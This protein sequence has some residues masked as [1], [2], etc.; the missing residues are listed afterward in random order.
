MI[1]LGALASSCVSSPPPEA[2]PELKPA[3]IE[4][5]RLPSP[6][7]TEAGVALVAPE[8]PPAAEA[9]TPLPPSA[10]PTQIV[11]P[12][13]SGADDAPRVDVTV[14]S[15]LPEAAKSAP[16]GA[17]D[18]PVPPPAAVRAAP[19]APAPAPQRTAPAAPSPPAPRAASPA[20]APPAAPA[21]PS[22]A[23]A[24]PATPAPAA[25][26][27]PPA[28]TQ[29]SVQAVEPLKPTRFVEA[30]R[31]QRFEIR[32]LGSGWT[33][34]G[35]EDGKDDLRFETRRFEGNEAVFTLRPER[36]DDYV[37]RFQRNDPV[38]GERETILA[39]VS[40]RDL[41]Q[42]SSQAPAAPQPAASAA[43]P[44]AAPAAAGSGQ[45]MG[46]AP[47]PSPEAAGP[48]PA[49]PALA[50]P[51]SALAS[52]Q[53]PEALLAFARSELDARRVRSALDALD[54]YVELFKRGTD[55]LFYLY[56]LAYEQDTPFKDIKKAHENYKRVRD[57][58]PRSLRW[59]A[60]AERVAYLERHFYGLR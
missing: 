59:R 49:V 10:S 18:E 17:I 19:P 27:S 60:A 39:K 6:R 11:A 31:N 38:S 44:P 12:A 40:V 16:R 2:E 57:E 50:A 55:E 41:V 5:Y 42:A 26:P 45:D 13:G 28:S 35:D 30:T 8:P 9:A 52:I 25:I 15:R 4:G 48:A 43:A 29:R 21:A 34:L 54:R 7:Q 22:P 14:L 51:A 33:Y 37:L 32:L 1:G 56:G 58:Y 20:P 3:V 46:A 23:P 53:E 36:S 47:P 24:V